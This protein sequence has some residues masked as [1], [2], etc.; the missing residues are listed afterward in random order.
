MQT[1]PQPQLQPWKSTVGGILILIV[2]GIDALAF[3]GTLLA[4]I[5]LNSLSSF[6]DYVEAQIYPVT[7]DFF[8]ALM[9]GLAVFFAVVAIVAILGGISALQRKRWGLAL[10]GAIV[11]VFGTWFLGIP[12]VVFI[13]IGRDE[14][15]S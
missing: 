8:S 4:A 7:L 6:M 2:G 12:A 1:A 3:L 5:L 13:A 15:K 10:A 14:F 9:I 11:S